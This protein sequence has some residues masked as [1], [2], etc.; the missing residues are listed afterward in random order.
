M[1]EKDPG[2][3]FIASAVSIILSILGAGVAIFPTL[4]YA[5]NDPSRSLTI[6]N[7]SSSDTSLFIIFVIASI[8][9]PLILVY[10]A[11]VYKTLG[12]KISLADLEKP[13]Y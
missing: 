3:T 11:W 10:T 1:N 6:Y 2:Q 13:T 5:S 8:A 4:V 9:L 7:A 12:G